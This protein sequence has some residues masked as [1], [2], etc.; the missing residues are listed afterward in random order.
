VHQ[1]R[2]LPWQPYFQAVEAIAAEF[3]GR[4]HWGK[5]HH[6]DA[7]TLR[8]RYPRFDDFITVRDRFDPD[9][10]FANTYTRQVLGD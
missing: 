9:R 4:P 1:Y 5:R 2:G 7:D 3:G 6:L 10:V 8:R